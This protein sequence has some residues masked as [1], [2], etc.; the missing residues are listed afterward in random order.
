M[1]QVPVA[2]SGLLPRERTSTRFS[3]KYASRH[4]DD[5]GTARVGMYGSI[6]DLIPAVIVAGWWFTQNPAVLSVARYWGVPQLSLLDLS[7][8]VILTLCWRAIAGGR[9]A[10]GTDLARKQAIGSLVAAACCSVLVFANGCFHYSPDRALLL[11]LCFLVAS[12]MTGLLWLAAAFISRWAMLTYV[13]TKREVILVGSGRRAQELYAHLIETPTHS[14]T[15]IVDDQFTGTAEMSSKY[16]GGINQLERILRE[17]PV[18]VVYCS[19]PVKT[20][21]AETQQVISTCEKIGVEVRHPARLFN[22]DIAQIDAYSSAHGMFAILRMVRK[23]SRNYLK[24]LIDIAGASALLIFTSPV[25][26]AAAIAIKITS[27]GPVLFAQERYGLDRRRFRIYKL[28]T[29][30]ED[31]EVL[32]AAYESMNEL[33]GPVFKI[34]RDPRITRIGGFLRTTSIDELPQLW[35]VLR[36]DMSLVGP[37]PLAVR[38]VRLIEDSSHLRRFSVKPGIT[39]IWQIKGRN[40]TDFETWIRQDLDYIDNWSLYLDFRILVA[41]VPAVLRR[42]GAM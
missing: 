13:V 10:S 26:L 14:V 22:T 5:L 6:R 20:M 1:S 33:G 19:L 16:M 15:G 8:L 34:R 40:A 9:M 36:G 2:I 18:A 23:G 12:A 31:A 25:L 21:Y 39:C 17:H 37:R 29:M 41:T 24:R 7:F 11:S 38:D 3:W 35:N 30:V 27:P 32:Q 28:R 42:R 4:F